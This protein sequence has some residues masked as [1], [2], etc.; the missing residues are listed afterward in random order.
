[1]QRILTAGGARF[2]GWRCVTNGTCNASI[3]RNYWI[4]V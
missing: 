3:V 1:M 4:A 2:M